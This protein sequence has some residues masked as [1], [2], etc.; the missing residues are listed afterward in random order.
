MIFVPFWL[1][2]IASLNDYLLLFSEIQN[3]VS[4]WHP[5]YFSLRGIDLVEF[6][7]LIYFVCKLLQSVKN[8]SYDCISIIVFSLLLERRLKIGIITA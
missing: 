1:L 2:E 5:I 6:F 3:F 8:D 4:F 7:L